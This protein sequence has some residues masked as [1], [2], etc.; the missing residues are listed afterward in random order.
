M[1]VGSWDGKV[2]ALRAA[3]GAMLW[4]F[5]TGKRYAVWSSPAVVGGVVYVGSDDGK[6]Y[7]LQASN[8]AK[9]WSYSTGYY[10]GARRPRWPE[11][12]CSWAPA[13]A[14]CTP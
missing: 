11:D 4:S 3:T 7:A 5:A 10:V 2:Y 1:Y 6:V 14:S 13:T 12:G 9:I 8:G